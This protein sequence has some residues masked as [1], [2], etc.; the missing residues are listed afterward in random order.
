MINQDS[1]PNLLINVIQKVYNSFNSV[2]SNS[3]ELKFNSFE[4]DSEVGRLVVISDEL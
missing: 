1:P 4:L 2:I 3:I